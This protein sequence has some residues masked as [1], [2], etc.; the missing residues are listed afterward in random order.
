M[1]SPLYRKIPYRVDS[2]FIVYPIGYIIASAGVGFLNLM[3]FDI[4]MIVMR[5]GTF[6]TPFHHHLNRSCTTK[7]NST[8]A[9]KKNRKTE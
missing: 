2:F 3:K 4:I 7:R 6:I 8:S 5:G 9:K 1:F